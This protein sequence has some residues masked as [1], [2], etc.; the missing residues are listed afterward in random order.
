MTD[1]PSTGVGG[2][3]CAA[4]DELRR[5]SSLK[6]SRSGPDEL[7]AD[8]AELDF[9]VAPAVQLALRRHL[10]L[11]DF[12]YPDFTG[13][14]PVQLT[15]LFGHRML[16]R[17]GWRPTPHL[18]E[19]AAQI[20][21]ALCCVL[22]AVT[23]PGDIVLTHSPTYPPFLAAIR[24]LRRRPVTIPVTT[25]AHPEQL[26][27]TLAAIPRPVRLI[28]LCHPHN[29]TGHVFTE[30]ELAALALFASAEDAVVF[31]DEI[32]QDLVFS[33]NLYRPAATTPG[34]H[35]RTITFTSA[36]KAFNIPGLR[37]AIGHFG[38]AALHAAYTNLP[39][40]LRNGAGLLGITA[41]LAAWRHGEDWLAALRGALTAN[42]R[43]VDA[44]VR[45]LAG[46]SWT[47]PAAGFLAWLDLGYLCTADEPYAVLK[48]AGVAVQPGSVYGAEFSRHVRLNFG[49]SAER[50]ER[51]LDRLRQALR[52]T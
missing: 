39:W 24:D 32:Y 33:P 34:L 12:G 49:T 29:P 21:Q 7:P 19:V 13:G 25:M 20:T 52:A 41:T 2:P 1:T 23:A 4:D 40:H 8:I 35:D 45:G 50:L 47:T 5:R 48:R 22:L 44:T 16:G 17:F 26:A 43:R 37:C 14:T 28:V 38:T 18:V 51:I 30:A 10:E 6:W 42:R 46:A 11:S 36:A 9:E 31:S 15:E 27:L 3:R